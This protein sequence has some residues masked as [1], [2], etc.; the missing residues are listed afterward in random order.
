MADEYSGDGIS[1]INDFFLMHY[2]TPR[3]SG[4]YPFGSGDSPYQHN[5]DFYT[6]VNELKAKGLSE[7]EIA[8][9]EGLSTT[10]LRALYSID[11][12]KRRSDM[13]AYAKSAIKD[14]KNNVQIGKELG[15]KYNKGEDIG[16]STVRSLLNGD[17]EV[18]MNIAKKT[19]EN[20]KKL[21]DERGMI[22]VGTGTERELGISQ[23]KMTDALAILELEGYEV[24]GARVPQANNKGKM[25]TIKV[26]CRPGT[27]HKDI[28]EY[29][30]ISQIKDYTS[31]DNGDTLVPSF[32]YPESLDSNRLAIRYSDQGGS[33]KDGVVEIRR[34]VK[35]LSLGEAN[36]SQVRILVDGTHYIK[37]M[38]VYSDGKDMPDGVDL[39]FNT[40]KPSTTS[41]LDVLKPIDKNIKK[42]PDNPFGSAIK[43]VGGQSYYTGEDGK[44]HLSL[45]NKRSDEGDWD[46]WSKELP[47]QFLSKQPKLLIERQLKLAEESK[48]SELEEI[49]G[50]TN[51]TVKRA[52][53]LEYADKCDR[54]AIDLKAAP[55]P[56]QKYQVILPIPSLKDD[57]VY[58]PNFPDGATVALVR[59]PH[60]GTFEIPILTVNNRSKEGA[61]I[62]TPNSRDAIGINH[63]VAGILSGADFDGDTVMV[64]PMS[65]AVRIKSTPPFQALKDFDP[66]MSYGPDPKETYV[67]EAGK[68]H[69]MRNGREYKLM[70]NTQNEMG[71]ISNLITDMTLKGATDEEKIRAVRHSMVVIDADKHHLDYKQ[72]YEDNGIAALHKKYQL[73]RDEDGNTHEGAATLLSRAKSD[74][75]VPER[76]EGAY[77]AKD[78]G[79]ILTLIDDKNEL[80]LDEKTG[81][82]YT[83]KEKK[84][85]MIDPKTGKKLYRETG[86]IYTDV[87]YVDSKGKKAH[88]RVFT[89][90]GKMVYKDDTGLVI[91]ITK[92]KI[93][94]KE[95]LTSTTKMAETDDA[96]TLSSNTVQENL[97]AQYANSMKALANNARKDSLTI[98]DT[99]YSS[100]AKETY[101]TEVES[102]KLHLDQ[103]LMNAP[104]ERQAQ[105]ITASAVKAFKEDNTDLSDEELSKMSQRVLQKARA[106]VGAKRQPVYISDKEW[107]AIQAGAITPTMLRLILANVDDD[108]LKQIAMPRKTITLM[109]GE[110]SRLKALSS[111]GYTNAEI[112]DTLHISS[113]TVVKYLDGREGQ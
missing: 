61:S 46:Q 66:K 26:L 35:D 31:H 33:E 105:M 58:A 9:G 71:R 106:R 3:H 16:E 103:A 6:H 92:E 83:Q 89:Q 65:D 102:L 39:I 25:T 1:C 77:V 53:L 37:G 52:M 73:Q 47:S 32:K 60:G 7:T 10:Q 97:Y 12:D 48:R 91:P 95:A 67:D 21:A 17:S 104:R 19:S 80:Y 49:Y 29:D 59:Y 34:G 13:V 42:D 28:Y 110:V 43:E 108:R 63:N 70:T 20:L 109:K 86:K 107:E 54:A 99:E 90:N 68:N 56:G 38:A 11:K 76:K 81:K 45:I 85:E 101:A 93:I 78:N 72:S 36:Y 55:F 50:V 27:E 75:R 8:E 87:N 113:S 40:N 88:A 82:V 14:G 84:T 23:T 74:M 24:F 100:S 4:R 18:R 69:Y 62:I 51:P 64:V 94:K 22:D 15:E 5:G 2:G 41:K 98:K 112:A 111:M 96:M 30:K 44:E 57:E 79:H